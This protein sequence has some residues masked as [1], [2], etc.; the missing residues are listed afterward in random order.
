MNPITN[1]TGRY[2]FEQ[3]RVRLGAHGKPV[4]VRTMRRLSK[5]IGR[6]RIGLRWVYTEEDVL[7][8]ER[9]KKLKAA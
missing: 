7:Q 2:D 4:S 6:I 1:P 5:Q 8:F 9:R 3:L